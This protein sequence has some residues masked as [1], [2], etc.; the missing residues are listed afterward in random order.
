MGK[1][2]DYTGKKFGSLYV[3]CSV[4]Y[5]MYANEEREHWLCICD[6]G[7]TIILPSKKL[8]VPKNTIP[9][10]CCDACRVKLCAVCNKPYSQ[11]VMGY[12]CPAPECQE[13]RR[14]YHEWDR[15]ISGKRNIQRKMQRALMTDEEL[16][17]FNEKHRIALRKWYA[18]IKA[19]PKRHEE[20][21]SRRRK[22]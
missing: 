20:I 3:K 13:I 9:Y 19:D 16:A 12:V 10:T 8:H 21:L 5:R 11:S 14:Q 17:A 22:R 18:K 15:I 1:R 7:G 2:I 4:G 6:C